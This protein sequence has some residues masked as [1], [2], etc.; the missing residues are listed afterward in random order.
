MLCVSYLGHGVNFV[1]TSS[2]A[3]DMPRTSK[4]LPNPFHSVVTP[5]RW[6]KCTMTGISVTG[7]R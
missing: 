1:K 6:C 5:W 4:Q 3:N 2:T 7:T